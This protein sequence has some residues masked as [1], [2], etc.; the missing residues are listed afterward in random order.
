M[1]INWLEA[2]RFAVWGLA[3]SGQAAANLLARCGKSVLISDVRGEEELADMLAGLDE[4]VEWVCGKNVF[5]DAQVIVVSPGLRPGL[6]L[7]REAAHRGIPVIS[8]VELAFEV[9]R[10]PWLGITGTDGKTTTTSLVGA[11]LSAA[12]IEH[13][14]GGNIGTALCEIVEEVSE[15]GVIVAELS[16]NQLWACHHLNAQSA[17]LTNLAPDHLDY[18]DSMES[19]E[20]A[21]FRLFAMQ[22]KG[23]R[24]VLPAS[25]GAARGVPVQVW[26]G[27]LIVFGQ[28]KESVGQAR[29]AIY[30]D[31]EG[32]GWAR[33]G[34]EE[35]CWFDDFSKTQLIGGHNQ[36]NAACAAALVLGVGVEFE[37]MAEGLMNFHPL[38]HRME[39]VRVVD[40]VRFI[41]D[42]KA[43]NPHASLAGLRGLDEPFIIIAGGVDKGL[44]MSEWVEFVATSAK[45]VV[46][47]G[48]IAPGLGSRLSDRGAK[49]RVA[50]TLEEAVRVTREIAEAGTTVVLSPAC[51][52]YDMF[53]SYEERGE[54][55]RQA[56]RRL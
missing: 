54:V 31:E 22:S 25:I 44:D 27:E 42:S 11:M 20:A 43:T 23:G 7:F 41:N 36:L 9:S 46:L 32:R 45:E 12:G 16:A 37:A 6:P 47:I 4:R 53:S 15:E 26:E 28:G 40:G 3:R 18:F 50:A 38:E 33:Q 48:A 56:V 52:S 14:V 17:A 2:K 13:V 24:A 10:A 35:I 21:K 55:F 8:E 34:G 1:K 30:F 51:S 5:G 49:V 19:Y 29:N 39:P